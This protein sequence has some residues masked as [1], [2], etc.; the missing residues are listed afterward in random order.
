MKKDHT[1]GAIHICTGQWVQILYLI[2][3]FALLANRLLTYLAKKIAVVPANGCRF[4]ILLTFALLANR[5]L[6]YLAKKLA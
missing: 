3:T 6:A 1:T 2:L 4:F 5:L